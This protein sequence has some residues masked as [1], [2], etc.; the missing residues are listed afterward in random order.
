[1]LQAGPLKRPLVGREGERFDGFGFDFGAGTGDAIR[2]FRLLLQPLS[3]LFLRFFHTGR[4][5]LPF[6]ERSVCSGQ[7]SFPRPAHAV[8][9]RPGAF[10]EAYGNTG[11]SLLY[12][13]VSCEVRATLA[14]G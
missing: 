9:Q 4:L 7:S 2:V 6:F 10:W 13:R 5:F 12:S 1:M 8:G 3:G 14:Q 11:L